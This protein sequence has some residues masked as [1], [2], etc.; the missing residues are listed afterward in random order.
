[1]VKSEIWAVSRERISDFFL[2]QD[3]VYQNG[4]DCFLYKE[5]EIRLS[6]R[7]ERMLGKLAFPATKVD[8]RGPGP[9][10]EEIYRRFF[11]RFI[12]AGA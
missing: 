7:S 3:D 10:T 5:C 6:V 9:D 2:S 11:L 12:S 4:D 1:M 8:F